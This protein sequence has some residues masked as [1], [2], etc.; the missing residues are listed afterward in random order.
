MSKNTPNSTIQKAPPCTWTVYHICWCFWGWGCG[1]VG[2]EASQMI[3]EV[4]TPQTMEFL[5]KKWLPNGQKFTQYWPF[6][7]RSP[8]ARRL[9]NA[10]PDIFGGQVGGGSNVRGY[11]GVPINW[12]FQ[13]ETVTK[14]TEVHKYWAFKRLPLHVDCNAFADVFGSQSQFGNWDWSHA[15]FGNWTNVSS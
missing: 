8:P 2:W 15:Q 7:R 11:G 10:F 1:G 13:K 9:Y 3:D 5:K 14:R 6:T 12:I 4:T